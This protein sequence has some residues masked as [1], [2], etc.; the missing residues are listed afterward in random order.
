MRDFTVDD[1]L[2]PIRYA[3]HLREGVG[4]RFNA[5][6]PITDGV[7]PLPWSFLLVP[8]SAGTAIEALVRAKWLGIASMALAG[9]V[10]G[11]RAADLAKGDRTRFGAAVVGLVVL[12]LAFPVGAYAASGMETGVATA[13]ATVAAVMA[14]KRRVYAT[15]LLAG[16]AASLRPELVMW[17]A[18]LSLGVAALE[19][20]WKTAALAFALSIAPFVAC[21]VLRLAFFGRPVPL[22]VLAKPSDLSHGVTYAAA[23]TLVLLTPLLVVAPFSLRRGGPIA[24][25]LVVAFAVHFVA[26]SLAGGDWMPYA[27][28]VVPVAPSLVLA[29]VD[30]ASLSQP[31]W[32]AARALAAIVLGVL[33]ASNAAPAGRHVGRDRTELVERATPL[34]ADAKVIAALD[35]GWVSAAS[36]ARVVDLAGLTD[37]SIAVLPGGHTSKRVDTTMLL[38]RG[39][40]TVLILVYSDPRAAA[41]VVELRLLRSELFVSRFTRVAEIPFGTRGDSYAVYRRT[42]PSTP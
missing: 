29:F 4:Y 16:L 8:L 41:R 26:V 20:R 5:S 9:G 40:D 1:A 2:I 31:A 18:T 32:S 42:E 19:A 17:S 27:R 13:L 10:L 3:Q 38:D 14:S 34:L 12:G 35:I 33:V 36:G 11:F 15:A 23:A 7:T 25:V 28:L 30:L 24:R 37:P 21:V 6:G 39:V 22:S